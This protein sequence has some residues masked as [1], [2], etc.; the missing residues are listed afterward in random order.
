MKDKIVVPYAPILV[1][2]PDQS[3]IHLKRLLQIL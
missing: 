2:Q 1:D 3:V